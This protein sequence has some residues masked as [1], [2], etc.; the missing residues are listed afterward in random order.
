MYKTLSTGVADD[1]DE[2]NEPLVSLLF[3]SV[4]LNGCK[5]KK[6]NIDR[7]EVAMTMIVPRRSDVIS[8]LD[9]SVPWSAASTSLKYSM[10]ECIIY[11]VIYRWTRGRMQQHIIVT[12][13]MIMMT[14]TMTHGYYDNG[15]TQC[16]GN[17][18]S[19][20]ENRIQK[21][22]INRQTVTVLRSNTEVN[23]MQIYSDLIGCPRN[24]SDVTP[25]IFILIRWRFFHSI[26]PPDGCM[27]AIYL[28]TPEFDN[29]IVWNWNER[30]E[31]SNV[32][33]SAIL[34]PDWL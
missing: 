17:T 18:N 12:V 2:N 10:C 30:W 4:P 11:N 31:N 16:M 21:N 14:T 26:Y 34:S 19:K 24:T 22:T 5:A 8:A 6:I 33:E 29:S 25:W 27:Q 3:S 23:G 15:K 13:P 20:C 28:S 7:L 9:S 1:D 32:F